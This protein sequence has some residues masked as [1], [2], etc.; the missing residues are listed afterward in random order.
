MQCACK[1]LHGDCV[2]LHGYHMQFQ[3]LLQMACHMVTTCASDRGVLAH[4]QYV[5]DS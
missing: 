3:V 2:S 5:V 1:H 4:D